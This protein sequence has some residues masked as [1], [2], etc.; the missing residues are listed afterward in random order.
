MA[1]SRA[2]CSAS[3]MARSSMEDGKVEGD[4]LSVGEEDADGTMDILSVQ[5]GR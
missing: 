5:D 3:R 4:M 2:T 1:R